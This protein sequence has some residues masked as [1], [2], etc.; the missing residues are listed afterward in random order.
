MN[1]FF[2]TILTRLIC[3][4]GYIAN[5]GQ[6]TVKVSIEYPKKKLSSSIFSL[7]VNAK[8]I[9]VANFAFFILNGLRNK[10]REELNH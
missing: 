1:D 3:L 9:I 7:F 2:E 5:Q 10:G 8:L 6:R 4:I